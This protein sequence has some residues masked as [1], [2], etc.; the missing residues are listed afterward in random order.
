MHC[1][2]LRTVIAI[3][4]L[5]LGGAAQ[6]DLA[7]PEPA[8][9]YRYGHERIPLG[10][11]AGR[12]AVFVEPDS[13][14]GALADQMLRRLS[15]LPIGNDALMPRPLA[16]WATIDLAKCGLDAVPAAELANVVVGMTAV[17]FASPV[18][19]D[20]FGPVVVTPDVL[21]GFVQGT[22]DAT[23]VKVLAAEGL[24]RVLDRNFGGI[25]GMYRARGSARTAQEVLK[26]SDAL[27][28]RA[29]V[30]YAE[31]DRMF[32]ARRTDLPNDPSF[33]LQ[34][35][36]RNTIQSVSGFPVDVSAVRA[37]DVNRGDPS[38]VVVVIDEGVQQN[39]PD[40]NQRPGADFTGSGTGGGPANQCD[41]HG[42]QVAGCVSARLNNSIGGVGVAP[43]C[44]VA[45]AKAFVAHVPCSD[46]FSD[47]DVA[48][49][50]AAIGWAQTI[51]ARVTNT[52]FGFGPSA[53]IDDAY[54]QTYSSGTVHFAAAGND[55][56]GTIGYPAS[57]PD[58]NS[59]AA[60]D[61]TGALASFS[62]FGV[63]LDFSAPGAD[64]LTTDRTGADGGDP[65]DTVFVDGTSFASPYA[66]GV[67][68]LVLSRDSCL[69]PGQVEAAMR[70]GCVD[71]GP[72]GY[73]TVFGYGLVNAE[74][75]LI[76]AAPAPGGCS[77]AA[78]WSTLSSSGPAARTAVAMAF[79]SGRNRLVLFGGAA[80]GVRLNDTWEWNGTSWS[81]VASGGPPGRG[82][83]NMV[84]DSVRRRVVMF[85]GVT[86]TGL[87]TPLQDTWEWDG[88]AWF[89]MNDG[90]PVSRPAMAYDSGRRRTVLFGG[91]T[92][93]PP[94]QYTDDT[95]VWDGSN[96]TQVAS[97]GPPG[98]WDTKMSYDSGRGV[99]VLFGGAGNM[100]GWMGDTWEWDGSIWSPRG[101]GPPPRYSHAMAYD[102]ERG[103]TVLFGGVGTNIQ[104]PAL[105]D[106]WLWDG[107]T[108][109]SVP[110]GPTARYNHALAFEASTGRT[111][112]FGGYTNQG[113]VLGETSGY[114]VA[115]PASI[116]ILPG[117]QT[118][119]LNSAALLQASVSGSEERTYQW[120][121]NGTPVVDDSRVHGGASAT[122]SFDS[123]LLGDAG[124]YVLQINDQCGP[125]SSSPVTLTVVCTSIT[126]TQQPVD[127]TIQYGTS[128]TFTA[129]ANGSAP[130]TYQWK[131]DGAPLTD[132]GT[133]SGSQT[134]VLHVGPVNL[135]SAGVYSCVCTNPCETETSSQAV[136]AVLCTPPSITSQTFTVTVQDGGAAGMKVG[137]AGTLP[138]TYQWRRGTVNLSDG[139]RF[140]GTH[141]PKF[142]I[143]PV[144][145]TD[146]GSYNCVVTNPCG[147]VTSLG[148]TLTVTGCIGDF[149]HDGQ[150]TQ[151]DKDAFYQA[152]N[153]GNP[154]ADLNGDGHVDSADEALFAQHYL[155]GC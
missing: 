31:A 19:V 17:D 89:H 151:A 72:T 21:V 148:I 143:S 94:V 122:L 90:P 32:T 47:G 64:V 112:L 39:H 78:G 16:G 102:S 34:W 48:W 70:G 37:W 59:V 146:T 124:T 117:V 152:F 9:S 7:R 129:V 116:C 52:S 153:A 120:T 132:G 60:I 30:R 44:K 10:V 97:S 75:S 26:I 100:V 119:A 40:I 83:H 57:S 22:D 8:F 139:G 121:H 35:G 58:V 68:A 135:A 3:L 104:N 77:A 69:T 6:A 51:G 88:V 147:T 113:V 155:A 82:N 103:R 13:S 76:A 28:N 15:P 86:G 136:L 123:A 41:N 29:E 45:S 99:M 142:K 127:R 56:S 14:Q 74:R 150:V 105:G 65:G 84:Y 33:P 36:L 154:S 63:G 101:G 149:N 93:T 55:G 108:W 25:V 49:T 43:G 109:V 61:R 2:S 11:Q 138:F 42:T 24:D 67:A 66:A 96:W 46:P 18:F 38:I 1:E 85:G 87:G 126:I 125:V 79:D 4:S 134:S 80:N 111:L 20:T 50:V 106:T 62:Q 81:Q 110:S 128:T 107:G 145:L 95:W 141:T 91:A 98:R 140:S 12:L 92:N 130:L 73:D 118:I 5:A 114:K 27:S 23:A 131:K 54:S 53:A 71:L 137:A 133:I 144:A 115:E